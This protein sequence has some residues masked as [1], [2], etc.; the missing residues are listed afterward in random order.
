MLLQQIVDNANPLA[1]WTGENFATGNVYDEYTNHTLINTNA[2]L[3]VDGSA[4]PSLSGNSI[5]LNGGYLQILDTTFTNDRIIARNMSVQ[6]GFRAYNRTK[7]NPIT[8]FKPIISKWNPD[9]QWAIVFENGIISAKIQTTGGLIELDFDYPEI[10]YNDRWNFVQLQI[11][12]SGITL[13]VNGCGISS[14]NTDPLLTSTSSLMTIGGQSTETFGEDL[15]VSDISITDAYNDE[16][17]RMMYVFPRTLDECVLN[18]NPTHYYDLLD[19][20]AIDAPHVNQGS[21]G[22]YGYVVY[23][24]VTPTEVKA[25]IY[26]DEDTV[27]FPT[28]C[29]FVIDTIPAMDFTTGFSMLVRGAVTIDGMDSDNMN[30]Q[31]E[32]VIM[33]ARNS[34]LNNNGRFL[35]SYNRAS[36]SREFFGWVGYDET[37]AEV[38]TDT[39]IVDSANEHFTYGTKCFTFGGTDVDFMTTRYWETAQSGAWNNPLNYNPPISHNYLD[40][41]SNVSINDVQVGHIAMFDYTLPLAS[42]ATIQ[43]PKFKMIA[44]L[45]IDKYDMNWILHAMGGNLSYE[46]GANFNHPLDTT[47]GYSY[48]TAYDP[49]DNRQNDFPRTI[50][51]PTT[52]SYVG[53]DDVDDNISFANGMT[54]YGFFWNRNPTTRYRMMHNTSEIDFEVW[55]NSRGG[56]FSYGDVEV[57]YDK[58][59]ADSHVSTTT[60]AFVDNGYHFLTIVRD[61]NLL[62]I[63][64]DGVV[65]TAKV[66][67]S[68]PSLDESNTTMRLTGGPLYV[69]E[70]GMF[71]GSFNE[72][73]I[74]LIYYGFQDFIEGQ[75]T[76]NGADL[77]SVLLATDAHTGSVMQ[78]YSTDVNG[79]FKAF[80]PKS[81]D[82]E[83]VT[84]LA[85]AQNDN[86]SNNVVAHGP[87]NLQTTYRKYAYETTVDSYADMVIDM[88]PYAYYQMNDTSGTTIV[89][90][91]GNGR[92]GTA[93]GG[94]IVDRDGPSSDMKAIELDG[95]DGYIDLPDGYD[96]DMNEGVTFEFWVNVEL[97]GQNPRF[98]SLGT[99]FDSTDNRVQ[100]TSSTATK[101]HFNIS[102][103]S[104]GNIIDQIDDNTISQQSWIMMTIRVAPDSTVT[105]WV[106]GINVGSP[107]LTGVIP[108]VLRTEAYIGRSLFTGNAYL[109]GKI[110]NVATYDYALPDEEIERHSARGY[111]LPVQTMKSIITQDNP[112][113]YFTF[114]RL[115]E[116]VNQT[117]QDA[118]WVQNGTFAF[119]KN[120]LAINTGVVGNNY[121]TTDDVS[122]TATSDG[123]TIEFCFKSDGTQ[124]AAI[125]VAEWDTGGTDTGTFKIQLNNS[126]LI[127]V[128]IN[129]AVTQMVST[130]AYNDGAWHHVIVT[131]DGIDGLTLFIDGAAESTLSTSMTYGLHDFSIGNSADGD[132]STATEAATYLDD[133]AIYNYALNP[134]RITEHYNQFIKKKVYQ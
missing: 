75:C 36:S 85:L 130:T 56:A 80:L 117:D 97:I 127:S 53:G 69:N 83:T 7:D 74:A 55:M 26:M 50:S 41:W 82:G 64:V 105:Y 90:S 129:N 67:V 9:Q 121:M 98:I 8:G 23:S 30:P 78:T 46:V 81:L 12:S 112:T 93:V 62:Q 70:W 111:E 61:G 96:F 38:T 21:A 13:Y 132:V 113:I 79:K 44:N 114:D 101:I 124:V 131:S 33:D 92:D 94:V 73:D 115:V 122:L 47:S 40:I 43:P 100:L 60:R 134:T 14:T 88:Q 103:S 116:L 76:L 17:A 45:M 119:I 15:Y 118:T 126:N 48:T 71:N 91:S 57:M 66:M 128:H 58:D 49:R 37:G 39:P 89:D 95:I 28:G 25:N 51:L 59:V 3:G 108:T 4:N 20:P 27:N 6:F 65:A 19:A 123:W 99:E 1:Y 10:I 109:K 34:M 104:G 24:G 68:V 107:T 133:L 31:H 54:I 22:G 77:P 16:F 84:V 32:M 52:S 35:L 63:W 11:T 29:K 2:T 106:N 5:N 86:D 72:T 102:N 18:L 120:A 125:L 87:Y 110:S 42:S